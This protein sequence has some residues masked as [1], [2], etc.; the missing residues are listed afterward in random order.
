MKSSRK[1]LLGLTLLILFVVPLGIAVKKV[2]WEFGRTDRNSRLIAA[3]RKNDTAKVVS[4]LAQGAD[5]NAGEL[6]PD[7]RSFQ[8][9][10]GDV[11][12]GKSSSQG[13][14]R[15]ALL[16]ALEPIE[17]I[18]P[19]KNIALINAL[20]DAGADVNVSDKEGQTPLL[21]AVIMGERETTERLLAKGARIDAA[22]SMGITALQ[23]AISEHDLS[24]MKVLVAHGA[25]VN[26]RGMHIP[27]LEACC[28]GDPD[29]VRVLLDNGAN[30][31]TRDISGNTALSIA[32]QCYNSDSVVALLLTRRAHVHTKDEHGYTPLRWATKNNNT[33]II[34]ML[35]KAGA[36]E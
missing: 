2:Y 5:A 12:R 20:L 11:L 27:L 33:Q 30:L 7:L 8:Q 23:F 14:A 35:K 18:P 36:K 19:T 15:S 16:V 28:E 21:W 4:L 24:L 25:R 9:K 17:S 26:V 29:M 6:P 1:K 32:A 22:N 13:K 31:E 10:L 3:I 34:K